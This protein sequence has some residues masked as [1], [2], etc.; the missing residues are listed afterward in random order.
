MM[1]IGTRLLLVAH[2]RVSGDHVKR[3]LESLYSSNFIQVE[4]PGIEATMLNLP[5]EFPLHSGAELPQLLEV[6]YEK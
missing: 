1:Q 4:R 2:K 3:L 5:P 6:F